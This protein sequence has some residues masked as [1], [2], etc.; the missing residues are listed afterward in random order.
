V[1]TYT[2][3]LHIHTC[4][5]P[6]GELAMAPRRIVDEA[7]RRGIDLIAVTDHNTAQMCDVV[8]QAAADRGLSF[9]YGIELQ[10]REEVHLLAY[11][12]DAASSRSFSEMVYDH[13]P[14]LAARP[15][16]FGDQV[17]V[18]LDERILRF[19]PR[20][21]LQ[22]LDLPLEDVVE[23]VL[24][25]EGLP[26]PAHVTRSPYGMMVQLGLRPPGLHFPLV[27]SDEPALPNALRESALLWGSDAH[28]PTEIGRRMTR[29]VIERPSTDE[30]RRAAAGTGGRSVDVIDGSSHRAP[31]D[32]ER[33]TTNRPGAAR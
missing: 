6:C 24:S 14:P 1:T 9:L 17:V 21:L 16:V 19:E 5:S 8:A 23:R 10:T 3:D 4:L 30:M 22:S 33:D 11:F 13:L 28:C 27:E 26:V 32:A 25:Y 29:F 31:L 18:D 12:D 15:E 20:L 2:A 7:A